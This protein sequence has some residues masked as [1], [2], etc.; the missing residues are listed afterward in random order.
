MFDS[1]PAEVD[2][3]AIRAVVLRLARPR[4][5]GGYVIERA[6]ILASGCDAAA[7]E[8]WI[9]AHAGRPERLPA[10]AAT[11]LHARRDEAGGGSDRSP[12]RFLLPPG[13]LEGVPNDLSS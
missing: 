8:T 1:P 11:G 9:L 6:A 4:T 13:A 5:G 3:D 10:P 12:R 7:I 2:D